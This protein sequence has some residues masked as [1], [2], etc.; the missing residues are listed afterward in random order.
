MQTIGTNNCIDNKYKNPVNIDSGAPGITLQQG[1]ITLDSSIDE[2]GD[3]IDL[4]KTTNTRTI[5]TNS[6]VLDSDD[7][8][9][10][11][12]VDTTSLGT[13]I[14]ITA[15]E[16]S[17]LT[18]QPITFV[19]SP[20]SVFNVTVTTPTGT[21]GNASPFSTIILYPG[22][23]LRLMTLGSFGYQCFSLARASGLGNFIKVHLATADLLAI[24]GTPFT[25]VAAPGANKIHSF[26]SGTARIN[27][28][29]NTAFAGGAQVQLRIGTTTCANIGAVGFITQA[30]NSMLSG[31]GPSNNTQAIAEASL[32][33]QPMMLGTNGNANFTT[34]TGSADFFIKYSTINCS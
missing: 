23:S 28:T 31:F 21:F 13:A 4:L 16:P 25:V 18:D 20:N 19:N 15:P 34:G 26:D 12:L 9:R 1:L 33:N 14:S 24:G 22:D 17:G 2:M 30:A 5:V 8:N 10:T 7:F 3:E 27:S 6:V 32:V 11:I 29:G